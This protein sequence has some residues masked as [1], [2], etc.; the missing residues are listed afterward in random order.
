MKDLSIYTDDELR[1]ELK[2]RAAER[3]ANTP[4]E[5]KY[6]EFE[7]TIKKVDNLLGAIHPLA[8]RKYKPFV[9]WKYQIQ[10]CS[11]DIANQYEWKEYYMK[12]GVF[13]RDNAPQIGDRV[14][15]KYRRTKKQAEVFDLSKAKIIEIVKRNAE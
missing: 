15:L 11:I 13:K 9:F 2:R 1:E 10:D 12:Q 3:R 5:I 14:K 7:A 6:V 8:T 4:R